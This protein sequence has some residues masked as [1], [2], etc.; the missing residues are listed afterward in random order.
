M[1][2]EWV[3]L[4]IMATGEPYVEAKGFETSEQCLKAGELF[5]EADRKARGEEP[6]WIMCEERAIAI[7]G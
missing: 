2:T 3:L 5:Q 6:G 1:Q 7:N 4:L